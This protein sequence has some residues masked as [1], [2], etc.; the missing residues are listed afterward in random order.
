MKLTKVFDP[1]AEHLISLAADRAV[2]TIVRAWNENRDAQIVL[3]GGRSGVAFCKA[4]DYALHRALHGELSTRVDLNDLRVHFW[5][6]DERFVGASDIERSGA[7]LEEAM[8]LTAKRLIFHQVLSHD[9]SSLEEAV[10]EYSSQLNQV[11]GS[12]KFDFVALS[13]GEDGHLA[14]CFPG[15]AALV[16]EES[17]M[18]VPNSPKPPKER[19]TLTLTRIALSNQIYILVVGEAKRVA[20]HE[21]LKNNAEMPLELLRKKSSLGQIFLLTNISTN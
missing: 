17:V 12:Q 14:S 6:S 21:T 3:T 8:P 13:M 4:L 19:V 15:Q 7:A 1:S 18:A 5:L 10:S 11:L 20:L 2:A 9:E 16:A